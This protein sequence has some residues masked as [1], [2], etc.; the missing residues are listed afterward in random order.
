MIHSFRRRLINALL[1][2]IDVLLTDNIRIEM[3]LESE[4]LEYVLDPDK[5]VIIP[6]TEA[7]YYDEGVCPDGF[8]DESLPSK[9]KKDIIH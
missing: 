2:A 7:L 4:Y 5:N 8:F 6:E 1:Y 3:E 9:K